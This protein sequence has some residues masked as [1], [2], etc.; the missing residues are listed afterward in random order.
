MEDDCGG[1][2]RSSI[3]EPSCIQAVWIKEG[4]LALDLPLE[5]CIGVG[6][7]AFFDGKVHMES[8]AGGFARLFF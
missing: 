8:G 4:I 3:Y 6:I 1:R 5:G 2:E 7:S